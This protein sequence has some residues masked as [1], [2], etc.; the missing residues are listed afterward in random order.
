MSCISCIAARFFATRK[1]PNQTDTYSKVEKKT[2]N[3]LESPV[4]SIA[5]F[6]LAFF[7]QWNLKEKIEWTLIIKLVTNLQET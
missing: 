3:H 4:I 7:S 5:S 2:K 6:P 1:A